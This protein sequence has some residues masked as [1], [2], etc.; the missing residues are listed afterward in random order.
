MFKWWR[1][2]FFNFFDFWVKFPIL[3]MLCAINVC[4]NFIYGLFGIYFLLPLRQTFLNIPP[5]LK[6]NNVCL[7]I[8]SSIFN[9][10]VFYNSFIFKFFTI[11]L[12]ILVLDYKPKYQKITSNIVLDKR[13]INPTLTLKLPT[14]HRYTHLK[15]YLSC[16][17]SMLILI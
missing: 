7:Q 13:S 9:W 15:Y 6:K 12:S 16:Y 4:L 3:Q 5:L 11:L 14:S 10:S 2:N 8:N 1:R 17:L